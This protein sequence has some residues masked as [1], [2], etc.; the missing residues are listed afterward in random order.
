M[1]FYILKL[2]IM[3]PIIALLIYGSL[4]LYRKYQP[5][6]MM[7]QNSNSLNVVEVMPIGVNNKLAVVDFEGRKIL[8]SVTRNGV[9]KIDAKNAD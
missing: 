4:W 2:V 9:A 7:R 1:T 8:L 3:L 6:N 5:Q